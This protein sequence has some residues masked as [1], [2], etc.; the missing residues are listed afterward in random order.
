MKTGFIFFSL[1][2]HMQLIFKKNIKKTELSF[3]L[4]VAETSAG[5][6]Q[7]FSM[8]KEKKRSKISQIIN[9]DIYYSVL[10]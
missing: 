4:K 1:P 8:E 7:M 5:T 10:C 6:G 3:E 9:N 2:P